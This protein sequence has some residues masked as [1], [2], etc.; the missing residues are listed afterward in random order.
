[1]QTPSMCIV[2]LGV[3]LALVS[4]AVTQVQRAEARPF[5]SHLAVALQ[6]QRAEVSRL[7]VKVTAYT[8]HRHVT[9]SGRRVRSGVVA[10]S[11]D[12]ERALGV[13]F[14][15]RLVLEGVG[16]FVFED[17]TAAHWRRRVDIFMESSKAARQFGVKA[18]YVRVY[19]AS[20]SI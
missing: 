7:P 19:G 10:L 2:F 20:A 3:I 14:G 4:D 9:A 16:T 1:M 15:D 6:P 12:L 11:P 18:T 13:E 8:Q 17:R 5:T